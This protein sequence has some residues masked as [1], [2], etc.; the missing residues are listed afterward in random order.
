MEN[1]NEWLEEIDCEGQ[2]ELMSGQ[3]SLIKY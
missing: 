1:I 2:L 3:Q